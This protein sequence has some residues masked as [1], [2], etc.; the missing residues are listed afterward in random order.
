MSYVLKLIE[1]GEHQQQDFKT[2]IEDSRKIARTLS[3][4]ANTDGGRLLIGVKDNGAISGVD[5]EEEFHMIEAAAEMYCDP[6]I[7]FSTQIWKANFRT[8][9]Q[10]D[11]DASTRKPH[12]SLEEDG[13]RFAYLRQEDKNFRVNAVMVKVW[14][15]GKMKRPP[16]FKYT[17][18]EGKLFDYLRRRGQISFKTAARIT[19][20]SYAKT[21]NMLAQL[22]CWNI[23]ELHFEKGKT[24]YRLSK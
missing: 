17:E 8:V 16:G 1:E 3:A 23:L 10:V 12:F 11:I 18:L 21:E 2:R 5:P 24:I 9:L 7:G 19:R 14:E 15:Q 22:I 4:F 6:P 13:K 20:Q